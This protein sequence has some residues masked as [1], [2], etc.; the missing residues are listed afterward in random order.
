MK[1]SG[2]DAHSGKD[3]SGMPGF[4][5]LKMEGSVYCCFVWFSQTMR[6]FEINAAMRTNSGM[7]SSGV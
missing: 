1:S 6:P 7:A 3:K 4:I 2:L 5:D